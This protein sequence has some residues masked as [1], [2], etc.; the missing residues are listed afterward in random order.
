MPPI[1]SGSNRTIFTNE[2]FEV[3]NFI[4]GL[5]NPEQST[6]G[7]VIDGISEGIGVANQITNFI[8]PFTPAGRAAAQQAADLKR[9]ELQ[10]KQN[11]AKLKQNE[12]TVALST[13][14]A[15]ISKTNAAASREENKL[16]QEKR[17]ADAFTRVNDQIDFDRPTSIITA[18]SGRDGAIVLSN[19]E[20]RREFQQRAEFLARNAA[21]PEDRQAILDSVRTEEERISLQKDRADLSFVK[22]RERTSQAL[23]NSRNNPTKKSG[24]EKITATQGASLSARLGVPSLDKIPDDLVQQ[25]LRASPT[26]AKDEDDNEV[27]AFRVGGATLVQGTPEFTAFSKLRKNRGSELREDTTNPPPT[28]EPSPIPAKSIQEAEKIFSNEP[29]DGFSERESLSAFL[30]FKSQRPDLSDRDIITKLRK[31]GDAGIQRAINNSSSG[32]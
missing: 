31:L 30:Y 18:L 12:A 23:E 19:E 26:V 2:S 6:F 1:V 4:N 27:V 20:N 7:A 5:K 11:E 13:Q 10:I 14:A 16:Q 24:D 3:D 21:T 9:A 15:T 22:Q 25:I 8:E 32:G 29:L 28:E 17:E